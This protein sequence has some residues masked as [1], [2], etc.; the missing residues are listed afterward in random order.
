MSLLSYLIFSSTLF[1]LMATPG[2]GTVAV[3]ARGL[4]S[5]FP[6]AFALGMGMVL[7]DLVYLLV[8]IFGL[9]AIASI[10]GDIFVVVKYIGGGY[11]IYLGLKIFFSAPE[12][13]SIKSSKSDSFLKDFLTG[14]LICISNPKVILFYL[15]FLPTFVDLNNLDIKNIFII[16]FIV[17][18]L[19]TMV[20]L[21]YAYFSA[22][23]KEA[24]KRPKTQT[25]M[26]RFAGSV[27]AAAGAALII[28]Q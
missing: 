26:N 9:G 6:H 22:K 11:L 12:N 2:P 7:G 20:I 15:G 1:I 21:G 10:M 14:F 3:M 13:K 18:F 28:K 24:I 4:G 5:G 27:M 16:S 8:A 17:V 19:L 25:I 23:A